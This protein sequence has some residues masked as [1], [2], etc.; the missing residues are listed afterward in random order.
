MTE[1]IPLPELLKATANGDRAAF[2]DVYTATRAKLYGVILR[3]LKRNDW[4]DE[5]LQEV[6]LSIWN[7]A[8]S[9]K[10]GKGTPMTWMISIARNR[11]LDRLRRDRGE[12]PLDEVGHEA[13]A[14][15]APDPLENAMNNARARVLRDCLDEL[16]AKQR[17]CI[18]LAFVEGYT[19]AE[20]STR[21][22][23]PIGTVKSWIRRSQAKL[24]DCLER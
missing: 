18:V 12:Q 6:Y 8:G 1:Q 19:H 21:L 4:S 24:K 14:D 11:A 20:L 15:D 9:Y 2:A 10:P 23:A 17:A 16:E 13:W 3:I 22:A 5:V 7:H